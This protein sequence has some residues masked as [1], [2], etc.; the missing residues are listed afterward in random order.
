MKK[1]PYGIANYEKIKKQ[2]Y[3]F[4]DKTQFIE[5]IESLGSQYL[6]FLR[7]RRFG[8][9]LFIS[10][11]EH[12]YDILRKDQFEELFGDTY[13]GKNPTELRNSLPVLKFNFS[14]IPTHGTV[15]EVEESFNKTIKLQVENFFIR[16]AAIYPGLEAIKDEVLSNERAGDILNSVIFKLAELNI[17]Y[18]LLID[19][20]DNFAN[21]IL[22]EHGKWTYRQVTHA[23]GF[24][25]SF[26][27]VI[28]N[29][30]ENRSIERLFV[31]GVSPLVLSDVTSGMNIGD[32]ISTLEMFNKMVGLTEEDVDELLDYYIDKGK[33]KGED[34]DLIKE[35][36]RE[37][38]NNY[39]FSE[40]I[41]E[42]LYNTDIV[43]YIVN[44]YL[45]DHKLPHDPIDPNIRTDYGKLRYLI[46]ESKKVN[47]NFNVLQEIV[48]QNEIA[49]TLID[50]FS[51]EETID[52]TKFI[53]LL[54]YLG[55]LTIKDKTPGGRY[56]F[57]IPNLTVTTLL[58][59]YIRKAIGEVYD[60]RI[61][62]RLIQ[63]LFEEMAFNGSWK[64]LFEYL[65]KEFYEVI[66]SNR[67]FIWR[68]EGV[69][70]FL[71]TYLT[72][73]KLYIVEHEYETSAGYADIYLRKNWITTGLTRYEYLIEV[74]HVKLV[75]AKGISPQKLQKIREEAIE[76]VNRYTS[77]L[78]RKIPGFA[79]E[80][81]KQ[82]DPS[83]VAP[84][85]KKI[86]II[87]SSKKVELMEEIP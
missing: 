76:Q 5:K 45:Q 39:V 50:S 8:K 24:L 58:W 14:G 69:V 41:E 35:T 20:Y 79:E 84:E 2:N 16:Y 4:V 7:P 27:A 56:L 34:R 23:G 81:R 42:R 46:V 68:E 31:T 19:E 52:E 17:S 77:S 18:Y 40:K 37:H 83:I 78:K 59:E 85:L 53:S 63:N 66:K 86:I 87:T 12:Y 3:Y 28:K 75:R 80:R 57:K 82:G 11:L 64:P 48:D 47:G 6:F 44:K 62:I 10:I 30:T 29:G 49:S 74:K 55:L 71:L 51:M 70:M 25:R 33:I 61:N 26:F 1:I 9:S 43:L 22:I 72:L 54:Y 60:L 15:E 13:I 65:L 21:N 67:D 73:S 32:N 36:I 38:A